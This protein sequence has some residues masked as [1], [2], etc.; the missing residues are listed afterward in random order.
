M[1][2]QRDR[3]RRQGK[4]TLKGDSCFGRE[5]KLHSMKGGTVVL[6]QVPTHQFNHYYMQSDNFLFSF[7]TRKHFCVVNQLV[8]L[9]QLTT[10]KRITS[11]T[12][13]LFDYF[14]MIFEIFKNMFT[15]QL[16]NR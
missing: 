5:L 15:P 6:D 16:K 10:A 14:N 2:K 13:C 4:K 3:G 9:A 8:Q 7:G 11:L 1:V 12:I